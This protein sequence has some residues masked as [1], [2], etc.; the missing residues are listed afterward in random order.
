MAPP[1][2][3]FSPILSACIGTSVLLFFLLLF[4]LYKYNQVRFPVA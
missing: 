1:N 2:K 3:L 4:L